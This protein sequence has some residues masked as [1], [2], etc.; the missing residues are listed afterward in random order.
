MLSC[1]C[2]SVLLLHHSNCKCIEMYARIIHHI[3]TAHVHIWR[4]SRNANMGDTCISCTPVF[5]PAIC[6]QTSNSSMIAL[7]AILFSPSLPNSLSRRAGGMSRQV[8]PGTARQTPPQA[9]WDGARPGQKRAS[10]PKPASAAPHPCA[11]HA[12]LSL[13]TRE[14]GTDSDG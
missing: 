8:V 12:R 9:Q 11:S 10:D 3:Y 5:P 7:S 1:H 4:C 14:R 13:P 2:G 6:Q